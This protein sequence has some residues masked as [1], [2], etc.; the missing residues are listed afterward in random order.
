[1]S[2]D[3]H[4]F[5]ESLKRGIH[6][7]D[8]LKDRLRNKLMSMS[9]EQVRFEEDPDMQRRG[10]DQVLEQDT[11]NFD[12]KVRDHKYANAGDILLE[13]VSVVEQDIDGWFYSS[14]SDVVV[15]VFEN[16]SGGNLCKGYFIIITEA[17][18][19]WFEERKYRFQPVF[20]MSIRNGEKWETKSRVVPV[21]SFPDGTLVEFD[22]T[23]PQPDSQTKMGEFGGGQ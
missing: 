6:W 9:L 16:E 19:E 1:M 11:A 5:D 23:L 20:A 2:G 22:P 12:I 17:L 14:D 10:I 3:V 13:T 21:N 15:Y 4:D 18:R 8:E 7:E